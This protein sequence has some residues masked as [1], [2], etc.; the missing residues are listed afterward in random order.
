VKA[1]VRRGA[2]RVGVVCAAPAIFYAFLFL[3][4]GVLGHREFSEAVF[5]ATDPLTLAAILY[6]VPVLLGWAVSGF[7]K[8]AQ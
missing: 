1:R 2:H 5:K 3:L 6:A 7:M 4:S 8:D